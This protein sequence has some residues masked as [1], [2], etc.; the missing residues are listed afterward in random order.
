MVKVKKEDSF[1]AIF[2]TDDNEKNISIP[3]TLELAVD[4]AYSLYD[5]YKPK[6]GI[7]LFAPNGDL[8]CHIDETGIQR[9]I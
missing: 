3:T 4:K 9:I 8:V 2:N 6:N 1:Y 7:D 5:N